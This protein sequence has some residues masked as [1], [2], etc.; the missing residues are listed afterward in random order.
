[1][2]RMY[3]TVDNSTPTLTASEEEESD[4]EI[5]RSLSLQ[6]QPNVPLLDEGP[7]HFKALKRLLQDL[8][9]IEDPELD[10]F[11]E[12]EEDVEIGEAG[13]GPSTLANRRQRSRS[14]EA[15]GFESNGDEE[16]NEDT[17]VYVDFD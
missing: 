8:D 14:K 13:P 17:R 5:G 2:G 6:P 12:V 3:E 1:M 4:N 15:S 9:D 11:L 7:I 10:H 16:G